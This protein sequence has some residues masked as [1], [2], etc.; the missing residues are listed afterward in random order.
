MTPPPDPSPYHTAERIYFEVERDSGSLPPP[1]HYTT[2]IIILPDGKGIFEVAPDYEFNHPP[3]WQMS[4]RLNPA[5]M[6]RL[7][8]LFHPLRKVSKSPS[9]GN[10]RSVGGEH[11][12]LRYEIGNESGEMELI[13]NRDNHAN[14]AD[15]LSVLQGMVPES[16]TKDLLHR[17]DKYIAD[18]LAGNRN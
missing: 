1:Y 10:P 9:T 15:F 12:S 18:Y 3:H 8:S 17:R 13:D 6:T 14:E 7:L 4:F 16:I 2:R 5:Q 11:V